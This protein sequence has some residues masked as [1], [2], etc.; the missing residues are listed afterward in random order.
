MRTERGLDRFITFLDA[1][2]AIAITL[3]VFPLVDAL[4]RTHAGWDLAGVCTDE[5]GRFGTFFLSFALI[6]RLW[7]AHHRIVEGA[8][9]YDGAFLLASL[10]WSL[11]IVLVPFATRWPAASRRSRWRSWST[12]GR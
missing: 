5:V 9:A 2:V 12:R 6:A 3:L 10:T 7:L 8:G 1:V 4:G 11:T